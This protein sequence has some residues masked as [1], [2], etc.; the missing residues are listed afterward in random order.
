MS[1]Y[2]N[3]IKCDNYKK[4][5]QETEGFCFICGEPLVSDGIAENKSQV[6][7]QG[8]GA[9][10]SVSR[11]TTNTDSHDTISN[12][13]TTIVLQGTSYDDYTL[14]D[15]KNAYRKYCQE[16]IHGGIITPAIR[17][18][19]NDYSME[20]D[21]SPEDRREIEKKVKNEASFAGPGLSDLD[22]DNLEIIK[23][24]IADNT[25][26]IDEMLPKLEAMSSSDSEEAHFY[27]YMLLAASSPSALIR[28]YND[29]EQD[30]YW[31]TFWAYAALTK[32]GQKVKAETALR[33][34]TAW[35][36]QPVDN[37][38]ILQ[39]IGGAINGNPE[40]VRLFLSKARNYSENLSP[41]GLTL[42]YF[43]KDSGRRN[44]SKSQEVNFYL[45]KL[46]GFKRISAT[47]SDG[48]LSAPIPEPLKE[49]LDA[50]NERPVVNRTTP[51]AYV[52]QYTP[53]TSQKRRKKY[54]Y[55]I[56]AAVLALV[57]FLL[58]PK[59]TS[60]PVS[61]KSNSVATQTKDNPVP[62]AE[63]KSSSKPV[64]KTSPN[65]G[66]KK[67]TT[68]PS[69]TQSE[70]TTKKQAPDEKQEVKQEPKQTVPAK[71]PVAE[72][73]EAVATGD[74]E[75]QYNLG[76]RYYEGNGVAKSYSDAFNYLKPLAEEGYVKAYFPVAEMYH[77]GRGVTKNR[78][79]AEKWYQKAAAAGNAKAKQILLN[80]F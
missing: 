74:K 16:K 48:S 44:L 5:Q 9:G 34:L 49:R 7:T 70:V 1:K 78:D 67:T 21:L 71:D 47:G 23:R 38:Q 65:S 31:L 62:V 29:R 58:I 27:Y 24:T 54:Y 77:G 60:T 15:R 76:M 11:V 14:K 55:G 17:R 41:V 20:L 8:G 80:N 46:F 43:I 61:V 45:E 57:V 36:T 18:Q 42:A 4:P 35:D 12:N 40:T 25:I 10:V 2:C 6:K 26:D 73:K 32:N 39:A 51:S 28:K 69:K 56:A 3:N 33:E 68:Q 52:P 19:L 53:E 13:N 22:K 66:E 75:A 64:A 79:E 37:L 72:L 50:I 59:N 63:Q 30:I